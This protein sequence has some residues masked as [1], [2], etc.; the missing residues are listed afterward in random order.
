MYNISVECCSCRLKWFSCLF[1]RWQ[2][3]SLVYLV[4]V[5][6]PCFLWLVWLFVK[7]SIFFLPFIYEKF[8]LQADMENTH[9]TPLTC[10]DLIYKKKFR[11]RF[12]CYELLDCIIRK[13]ETNIN[14]QVLL[15]HCYIHYK[16]SRGAHST[17]ISSSS[18]ISES[19]T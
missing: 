15:I 7:L 12:F 6:N 14:M 18:L 2:C 19:S 16:S 9:S 13:I 17:K 5:A 11:G 1:I 10:Q 4:Y 8:Y 3:R